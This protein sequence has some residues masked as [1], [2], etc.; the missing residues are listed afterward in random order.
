MEIVIGII[1]AIAALYGGYKL[2]TNYD[3]LEARVTGEDLGGGQLFVFIS[4]VLGGLTATVLLLGKMFNWSVGDNN[5][6]FVGNSLLMVNF[7]VSLFDIIFKTNGVK[8]IISLFF[9]RLFGCIVGA[10]M[11]AAVSVIVI[12]I[13][14][15]YFFTKVLGAAASS[16]SSSSSSS[17]SAASNAEEEERIHVDGEMF[18][19]R[20][21]DD[22]FGVVTDDRGDR[23]RRGWGGSL[24]KIDD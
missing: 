4:L 13:I 23:W 5:I 2:V 9:L 14:I 21:K 24:S 12:G 16:N 19:R 20:V 15:L 18:D 6:I 17:Y 1:I 7:A 8:L 3:S 22:S 10:L 11:G